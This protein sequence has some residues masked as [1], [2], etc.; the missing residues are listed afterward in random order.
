MS[1]LKKFITLLL[2]AYS[3]LN[4]LDK[5]AYEYL[6]ALAIESGTDKSSLLH[7]YTEVYSQYFD[8][9]KEEP[10][11]FLEIGIFHGD[12]VKMW[13]KYFTQA[14]LHFIDINPSQIQ[15]HSLRSHYH[16]VSQTNSDGLHKLA[17]SIGAFDII[18]DDG[19]HRMDQQIISFHDLFPYVKSGGMYVIEDLATSYWQEYGAPFGS[20]GNPI[21]GPGTCVSFLQSLVDDLN[22]TAGVTMYSNYNT[23]PFDLKKRLNYFQKHIESIHFYKGLCIIKKR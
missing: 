4:A 21:P 18:I 23:V 10:I 17:R 13:E 15:Y 16:F 20:I 5:E 3:S 2:F 19:G 1:S 12:S 14:D 11:T 6:D 8:A 7:N 9:L 22:Y